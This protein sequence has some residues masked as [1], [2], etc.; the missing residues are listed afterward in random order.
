MTAT[1]E[2]ARGRSENPHDAHRQ[3]GYA[4]AL[5]VFAAGSATA[6]LTARRSGRLP[7]R[8]RWSDLALGAVA[9]HKLA[10]IVT[11][12][13]V[14]TPLR[15]PFT[16]FE[17]E[18]GSAEVHERP[19][20]GRWHTLGELLTCPFC[21]APW[22]AGSYV[23]CLALAPAYARAWAATFSVVGGAD[24]LQQVYARVRAD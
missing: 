1:T 6:L 18:A 2:A 14:V 20:G 23:A 22:V 16:E 19:R 24:F 21:L 4:T 17:G 10:R 11:Q 12:E 3:V 7:D 8:Y 5:S 15:A 9:T 13:G